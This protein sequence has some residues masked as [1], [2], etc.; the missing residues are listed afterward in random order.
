L[1]KEW[2]EFEQAIITGNDVGIPW[3][4]KNGILRNSSGRK[5]NK[6]LSNIKS[7]GIFHLKLG[8]GTTMELGILWV[9]RN[10]KKINRTEHFEQFGTTRLSFAFAVQSQNPCL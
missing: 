6:I 1:D 2:I 9:N 4:H 3:T 5:I 10:R 8:I 7:H